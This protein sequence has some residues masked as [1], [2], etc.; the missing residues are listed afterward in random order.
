MQGT[1]LVYSPTKSDVSV[2]FFN[3][4]VE[5]MCRHFLKSQRGDVYVAQF[6]L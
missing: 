1:D 4:C 5:Y 6:A 3:I 2:D